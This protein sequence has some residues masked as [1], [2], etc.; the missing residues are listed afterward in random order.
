MALGVICGTVYDALLSLIFTL[1]FNPK[2][3]SNRGFYDRFQTPV[4]TSFASCLPHI[5]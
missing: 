2:V 1:V 4:K 3:A 5:V